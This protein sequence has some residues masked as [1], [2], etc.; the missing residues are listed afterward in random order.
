[1]Y[2]L[3]S[4]AFAAAI[5]FIGVAAVGAPIE[6]KVADGGNG[7]YYEIIRD[8]TL[9]NWVEAKT[10]AESQ[11]YR[12]RVGQMITIT[13][14]EE[15]QF[16]IDHVLD[17]GQFWLGLTDDPAFGGTESSS[18]PDPQSSGWVWVSGEPFQYT[19]WHGAEPN[20]QSGDEHYIIFGVPTSFEWVDLSIGNHLEGLFIEYSP[21]PEPTTMTL[22]VTVFAI[23]Q[24]VA[25]HRKQTA[26]VLTS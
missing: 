5:A 8:G 20:N 4:A 12:G 1:M 9:R 7:H 2:H 14:E 15:N 16:L 25:K 23:F 11:S 18:F 6:W 21:V 22:L 26:A 13:S 19:N 17:D 24:I 3:L 10:A